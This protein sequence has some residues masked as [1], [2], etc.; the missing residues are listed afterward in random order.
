MPFGER[1]VQFLPLPLDEEQML[2]QMIKDTEAMALEEDESVP[3]PEDPEE[4][5]G[6]QGAEQASASSILDEFLQR[7]AFLNFFIP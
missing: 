3:P 2:E 7:Q 6:A 1:L 5:G 4:E